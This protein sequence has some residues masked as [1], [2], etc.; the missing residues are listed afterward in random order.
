MYNWTVLYTSYSQ[1]GLE[2]KR[3]CFVT[4]IDADQFYMDK[5]WIGRCPTKRP[6]H[7]SDEA[8]SHAK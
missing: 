3:K 8:F 4:E 7:H 2:R 6:Y 5:L 1:T